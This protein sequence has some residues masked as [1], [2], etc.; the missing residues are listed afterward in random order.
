MEKIEIK[1]AKARTYLQL[2]LQQWGA[3]NVKHLVMSSRKVKHCPKPH[4]RNEIVDKFGQVLVDE[5]LINNGWVGRTY[6][7]GFSANASKNETK[8]FMK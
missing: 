5:Y 8:H 4:C 7:E 3:S 6:F 1:K 2:P